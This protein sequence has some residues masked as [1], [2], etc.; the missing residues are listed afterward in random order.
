MYEGQRFVWRRIAKVGSASFDRQQARQGVTEPPGPIEVSHVN[1][2]YQL[3]LLIF[4]GE[5]VG[6]V[7]RAGSSG[8]QGEDL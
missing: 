6:A 4:L 2:R 8:V 5:V 7:R 1:E 3:L